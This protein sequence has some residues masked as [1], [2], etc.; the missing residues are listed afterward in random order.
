MIIIINR[1]PP[2]TAQVKFGIILSR[3]NYLVN[4]LTN[5]EDFLKYMTFQPKNWCY[6]KPAPT[7]NLSLENLPD[8]NPLFI[9]N[10]FRKFKNEG[11]SCYN[12]LKDIGSYR[13][14]LSYCMKYIV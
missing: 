11:I 12:D 14:I 1:R 13:Y 5:F 3:H 9:H 7:G 8:S 2:C 10:N 4:T 6:S